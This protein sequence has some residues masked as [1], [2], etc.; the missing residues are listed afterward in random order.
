MVCDSQPPHS[1]VVGICT[2]MINLWSRP[3]FFFRLKLVYKKWSIF[4]NFPVP[5]QKTM[6]SCSFCYLLPAQREN[7]YIFVYKIQFSMVFEWIFEQFLYIVLKIVHLAVYKNLGVC[8][9]FKKNVHTARFL[10]T[11][12]CT[13]LRSMYKNCSENHSKTTE[14]CILDTKM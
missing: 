10:Y 2:G 9:F 13:I 6:F 7:F 5:K 11:T 12:K 4:G 8:T 1:F 14:N 3:V